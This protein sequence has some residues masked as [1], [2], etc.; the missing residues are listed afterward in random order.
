MA[1]TYDVGKGEGRVDDEE[2]ENQLR[3]RA[4]ERGIAYDPSDL[5]GV[6]RNISYDNGGSSVES[7]MSS[8]LGLYD[9][10]ASNPD[11][12]EDWEEHPEY[13]PA[14]RQ[15]VPQ[16]AGGGGGGSQW[17]AMQSW[18]GAPQQQAPAAPDYS[19]MLQQ[20]NDLLQQLFNRQVEEQNRLVAEQ[21]ARDAELKAR[22]DSLYGQLQGR[23][24]QS[25]NFDANDPIIKAQVD[26]YRAEQERA[27]RNVRSDAAEGGQKLR[28]TQDRM[29]TERVA[30]GV[31]SMQAEL[32][33]RELSAKRAEISDALAS[34][35]SILTG[36]QQ[37][38]LQ[39]ELA[40]L[41]NLIRQQQVN[42]GNRDVDLRRELGLGDLG[43]GF[44]RLGLDTELGRGRLDLDT[45]L[46]RGDLSLRGEL[47]RSGLSNDLMRILLQNQQFYGDLGLRGRT[48]D[49]YYDLVRRGRIGNPI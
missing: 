22:Q 14:N 5:E 38:G 12:E 48:Q 9:E 4:E 40:T 7:A 23:A 45:E 15:P 18:M 28:P 44:G 16:A 30:Q 39:R 29:A 27:L 6:L 1:E 47:G 21:A 36:D 19:P 10:R 46:G 8:A 20:Q 11:G 17:S 43:L 3:K 31:A 49:D 26:N 34:M 2:L 25:I 37:A 24:Q 32:M 42:T 41:D 33:A 13:N 35:G